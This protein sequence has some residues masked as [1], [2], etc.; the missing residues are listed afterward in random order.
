MLSVALASPARCRL[1]LYNGLR[2]LDAQRALKTVMERFESLEKNPSQNPLYPRS[3]GTF[4]SLSLDPDPVKI[5]ERKKEK[6]NKFLET[7]QSYTD[8]VIEEMNAMD[9]ETLRAGVLAYAKMDREEREQRAREEAAKAAQPEVQKSN[10][11]EPEKSDR[12]PRSGQKFWF[13]LLKRGFDRVCV[14]SA[15]VVNRQNDVSPI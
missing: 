3:P 5:E 10:S 7:V 15:M 9:L 14:G 11:S 2:L 4:V 13:S 6:E 8:R 1:A 12:P